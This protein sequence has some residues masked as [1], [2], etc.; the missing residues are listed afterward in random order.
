[1]AT[2]TGSRAAADFPV[3]QPQGTGINGV[4]YGSYTFSANPTAGDIIQLCRLPAG[5][6]VLGGWLRS[7]DI[8]TNG[9]PTID[10]DVGWAANGVEA[11]DPDGLG[12]FGTLNGTAVANYLPEGGIL[13]PLNGTLIAGPVAFSAETV[14][15][16]V[17]NTAAATFAAA[18]F[19]VVVFYT[20][21]S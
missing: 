18:T 19:T 6:V 7:G 10:V 12:N 2:L 11:A 21:P 16:A 14:I 3:F 9:T 5:A 1:M 20:T 17:V 15:Q 13:V 4:A 8:D